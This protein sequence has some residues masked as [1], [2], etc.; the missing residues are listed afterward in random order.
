MV[1]QDDAGEDTRAV[2]RDEDSPDNTMLFAGLNSERAM[3]PDVTGTLDRMIL[4][5]ETEGI[6]GAAE[7]G[8]PKI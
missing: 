3:F 1:T 7:D 6:S 2:V 5:E 4:L 8:R